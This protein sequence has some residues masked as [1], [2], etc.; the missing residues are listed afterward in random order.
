MARRRPFRCAALLPQTGLLA[1][2]LLAALTS[3]SPAR[4]QA[5]APPGGGFDI[6]VDCRMGAVCTVQNYI[7][8]DPGPGWLDHNCGPLSYDGHR[9]VDFRVPTQIE[10]R[11]GVAVVAAADGRVVIARDGQPDLL[12]QDTGPGK[13]ID[14]RNGNWVAIDHGGGWVTTYAHLLKG[15]VAVKDGQRVARG[16]KLGLIGLSGNSD[17]PHLHF[18]V[19]YRNLLLD[20]FTGMEPSAA[21]GVSGTSLWSPAAQAALDY[22]PGGLLSAGFL[23]RQ[24]TH[25]EIM[26]GIVP[27]ASLSA[28]EPVLIFWTGSWGLRIGDRQRLAILAP[29]GEVFVEAE[30]E[31]ERNRAVESRFIGKKRRGDPWPAGTYKGLYRVERMVDGTTVVIIDKTVEVEVR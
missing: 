9:G 28:T 1:A 25:R 29:D 14:E 22:R 18:A 20:P 16:E 23:G 26:D 11:A 27:P 7:D 8:Y 10:M 6:P 5:P 31:V 30:R 15:S 13:T 21:C 3:A 19:T 4:A 17:F 24:P 2:A 12:M